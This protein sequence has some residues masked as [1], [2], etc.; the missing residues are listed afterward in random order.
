MSS[1]PDVL[2][3][4]K[5]KVEELFPKLQEKGPGI[6][7]FYY[8]EADRHCDHQK[9]HNEA[10]RAQ[11]QDGK[12]LEAGTVIALSEFTGPDGQYHCLVIIQWDCGYR[13]FYFES[14]LSDIR[15]F[16]LGPAG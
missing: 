16:D 9:H 11:L 4:Q 5:G 3:K 6:R 8:S 2:Y 1:H 14:D 13:R 10:W 15:V 7:V 12:S